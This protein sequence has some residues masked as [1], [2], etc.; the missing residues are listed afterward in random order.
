MITNTCMRAAV[1]ETNPTVNGSLP[2]ARAFTVPSSTDFRALGER[3]SRQQDSSTALSITQVLR[4][5]TAKG[6]IVVCSIHQP[7]SNIFSEFDKVLLLNKGRTV[8]YGRRS[9][10]VSYFGSLGTP[11]YTRSLLVGRLAVEEGV[12]CCLP[13]Q[14]GGFPHLLFLACTRMHAYRAGNGIKRAT[15]WGMKNAGYGPVSGS[16]GQRAVALTSRPS[17]CI[18]HVSWC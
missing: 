5:L 6:M 11:R 17:Q 4:T 18:P 15:G 16:P 13:H 12:C 8:Y 7:R 1:V 3:H 9:S 10:I 14:V 2:S